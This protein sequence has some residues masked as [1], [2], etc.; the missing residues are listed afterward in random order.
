LKG[1]HLAVQPGNL[2]FLVGGPEIALIVPARHIILAGEIFR[3]QFAGLYR[4]KS[5]RGKTAWLAIYVAACAALFWNPLRE[6]VRL[7][8]TAD[9]YSHVLVVPF[10]TIVLIYMG[11][12]AILQKTRGASRFAAA[13]LPIGVLLYALTRQFGFSIS[14]DG[15]LALA[16][17][18][19]LFLVWSGFSW[20]FGSRSFRAGL[21]PLLFLLLMIPLPVSGTDR[22]ILWLQW[23]SAEVTSWIFHA[24]GTPVVRNGLFFT[25][26]S[27]TIE[28]AKECSGIR[29]ATALLITCLAAGYLLLRLPWTRALLLFATVPVLILKNGIRI[30]TLTLL[31]IHVDPS[32][33]DGPLHHQG[34]VVFFAVGLLMLLPVLWWLQRVERNRFGPQPPGQVRAEISNEVLPEQIG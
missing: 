4:P 24:T 27:V 33:L 22:F 14:A 3:M 28:I 26:P 2:S 7:S 11:R 30:T 9:T 6:L 17:L 13:F 5:L 8:L 23:G 25:L 20:V 16:I 34:G 31:A 15:V 19:F 10:I 32:F 21:F 1:N 18:G 29:S 12:E